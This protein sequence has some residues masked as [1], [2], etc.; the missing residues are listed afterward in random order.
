[1]TFADVSVIAERLSAALRENGAWAGSIVHV[2]LPNVP[3][4]VPAVLALSKLAAIAGL[5]P[6]TYRDAEFRALN[7]RAP[8]FAYLTTAALAPAIERAV[9]GCTRRAITIAG[10][11]FEFELM[12]PARGNF[13]GSQADPRE[14]GSIRHR[15]GLEVIL[16]TSGSTGV[17]KGVGRTAGNLVSEARNVVETLAIDSTD[18]ILVPVSI[19]HAYGFHYGLLPMVF[20]GAAISIHR[21]FVPARVLGELA[22]GGV[23]V[24]LGVPSIYRILAELGQSHVA[25]LSH[26]RYLLSSTASLAAH[27]ITEFHSRFKAPICQA[28]GASETGAI[29]VHVPS[30]VLERPSSVGVA[31][32]NV[33]I[34]VIGPDR[35]LVGAGRGGEIR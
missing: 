6:S 4:F 20:T 10:C 29:S 14:T 1:M 32:R 31:A 9:A 16:F 13:H 22:S 35:E 26:V 27:V 19:S 21:S 28:Y 23:T 12:F 3:A 7:E 30:R 17:P 33:E 8:P 34:L 18:R 24:C 2:A 15:E 25:D 5:V 11:P